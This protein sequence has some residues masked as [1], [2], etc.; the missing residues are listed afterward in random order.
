MR[1]QVDSNILCKFNDSHGD[2]LNIRSMRAT[3]PALKICQ[4]V[5]ADSTP[6]K[7]M[8]HLAPTLLAVPV[9]LATDGRRHGPSHLCHCV[10][11]PLGEKK[12]S[13]LQSVHL[14]F[15]ALPQ[16]SENYLRVALLFFADLICHLKI[17][18]PNVWDMLDLSVFRGSHMPPQNCLSKYMGHVDFS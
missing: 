8:T 3:T 9:S 16:F 17:V 5:S 2:Q 12:E 14:V 4:R 18:C 7:G 11:L 10:H 1:K 13:F 6:Q 15:S